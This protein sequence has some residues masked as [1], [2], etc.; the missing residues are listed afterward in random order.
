MVKM[1]R[2]LTTRIS[3]MAQAFLGETVLTSTTDYESLWIAMPTC[4]LS[5]SY[6]VRKDLRKESPRM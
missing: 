5:K 3:G 2:K 4:W 6:T 1:I